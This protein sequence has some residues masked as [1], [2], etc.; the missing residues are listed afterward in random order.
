[1]KKTV[2]KDP[3]DARLRSSVR[4]VRLQALLFGSAAAAPD[5]GVLSSSLAISRD[6]VKL[7]QY[8]GE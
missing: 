3:L 4:E 5:V 7:P 1:M 8:T 2:R 6:Y